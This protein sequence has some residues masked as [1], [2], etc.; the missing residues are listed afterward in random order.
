MV[1]ERCSYLSVTQN[2][3]LEIACRSVE[4]AFRDLGY[5]LF[6][7]GSSLERANWRDVDLRCML[8]DEDYDQFIG[9]R[10]RL[11][12]LNTAIS[13]W[14]TART[15]LPID[16]QFQRATEANKEFGG[17]PR[18]AVGVWIATID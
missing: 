10:R 17:R 1:K 14:L 2:F 12:L 11:Y 13:E 3:N 9:D 8:T 4:E 18:N 6:Q 7:V 16:F 5:G 15:G